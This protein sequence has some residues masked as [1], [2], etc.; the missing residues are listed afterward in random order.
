[1]QFKLRLIPA[2]TTVCVLAACSGGGGSGGIPTPIPTSGVV[3]DGYVKGA[4]VTCDTNNNGLTDTGEAFVFSIATGAFIFPQGC[5]SP[6]LSS[7]GTSIDTD[8]LFVGLMRAT[9]GAKVISPLTTLVAHG[10]T[11]DQVNHALGLTAGTALNTLDPR[12]QNA[13]GELVNPDLLKK[14]LAVQQLLQKATETTAGLA[15]ITGSAAL[16]PIYDAVAKA[17]AAGFASDATPLITTT[18][19]GAGTI[20]LARLKVLVSAAETGVASSP[21]VD[22]AVKAALAAA[23]G[24]AQLANV[25]SPALKVQADPYLAVVSDAAS[26]TAVTK[27][28]QDNKVIASSVKVALTSG[29]LASSTPSAAITTLASLIAGNAAISIPMTTTTTGSNT[30]TTAAGGT[31]TTAAVGTTTTAAG[32]TTTTAAGGTTTTVVGK[33]T[34]TA[35]GGTTT[36]VGSSTTTTAGPIAGNFL[37]LTNDAISL[38]DGVS[39]TSYTMAQFQSTTGI[40]VKW[41]MAST[42]AIKF[43][44]AEN[45]SFNFVAGQTLEA[46][47]TITQDTPAGSGQVSA[48]IRNVKVTKT[49]SSIVL[50]VPALADAMVYGVSGDGKKNA[51]VDFS[52]S[53]ANVT[54]TLSS[55]ANTVSTVVLG[56]VVNY[57]VNGVSNDF[58]NIYALSGKYK[59]TVVVSQLPLSQAN[60]KAFTP[61]TVSVPTQVDPTTKLPVESSKVSVTGY[62]LVGYINLVK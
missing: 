32:G 43:K 48:Y 26:I 14:T 9:A 57:A 38:A 28:G 47:M 61:L 46:A 39:E 7:G 19:T 25:I 18:G 35:V 33:T 44:L 37:Y 6:M 13:N 10:A 55:V 31:T 49:G 40:D 21:T 53:V 16:E 23:G 36:T 30:T 29:E 58:S 2:A 11:Q 8:L 41:P 59:V 45:G 52:K 50:S 15:G 17:F 56:D 20:D 4:K 1:M 62:G 3:V 12:A 42:T 24:P 51:V 22:P 5:A 54:N 27:A 34:T 60:G